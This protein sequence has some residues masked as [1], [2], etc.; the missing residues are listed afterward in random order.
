M[1]SQVDFIDL[2]DIRTTDLLSIFEHV[3]D[4]TNHFFEALWLFPEH[5]LLSFEVDIALLHLRPLILELFPLTLHLR[6]LLLHL[7]LHLSHFL[8]LLLQLRQ[9]SLIFVKGLFEMKVLW[10]DALVFFSQFFF[11]LE[12]E[13]VVRG[14]KSR[15]LG[16]QLEKVRMLKGL[17]R[18]RGWYSYRLAWG[19]IWIDKQV[20]LR[21]SMIDWCLGYLNL[22]RIIRLLL[23]LDQ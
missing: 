13:V 7:L 23:R 19:T 1:D 16:S 14:V 9:I 6:G 8:L 5:P 4:F 20:L 11:E 22:L 15:V 2:T 18:L 10:F 3:L 12:E 21:R 17:L